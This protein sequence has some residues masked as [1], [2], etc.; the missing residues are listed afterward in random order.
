MPVYTVHA[1][2]SDGADLA[3]TDKF[4]F[5]RDGFHFWAVVAGLVWLAETCSFAASGLVGSLQVA[6]DVATVAPMWSPTRVRVAV[7]FFTISSPGTI[8]VTGELGVPVS[9]PP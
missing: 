1:P 3:A 2:V 8:A 6:D 4:E 5:V 9:T 7:Q